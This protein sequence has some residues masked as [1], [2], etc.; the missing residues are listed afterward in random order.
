[1]RVKSLRNRPKWDV[2]RPAWLLR[3]LNVDRLVPFRPQDLMVVT[4]ATEER[5]IQNYDRFGNSLR[6][7][8]SVEDVASILQSVRDLL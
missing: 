2:V 1:M 7:P 4:R 3:C 8:T 5:M 6:E